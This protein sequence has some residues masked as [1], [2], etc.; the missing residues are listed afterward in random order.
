MKRRD[1]L[2]VAGTGAAGL[3]VGAAAG[4]VGMTLPLQSEIAKLDLK[5]H[6]NIFNWTYY[7]N[8]PQLV[9]WCSDHGITLVYDNFESGEELLAV[10][11]ATDVSG[12][13]ICVMTDGDIPY[14]VENEYLEPIDLDKIPNF[15]LLPEEFRGLSY[16]PENEHTVL[17]SY[18]TTG[19]G[20]N[21]DKVTE[22][23]GITK[24]A[25]IFDPTK[26]FLEKY[27]GKI[28][29]MPDVTETLGAALLYLGYSPNSTD[30]DELD[31]ALKPKGAIVVSEAIHTCEL[32]EGYQPTSYV[33]SELRGVFLLHEAPRTEFMSLRIAQRR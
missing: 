11:E 28:T 12:Y 29:M 30:S 23:K 33:C 26:G 6:L 25:D 3:A 8:R 22:E 13:D 5:G 27:D 15:E 32:I 24:W 9:K 4:Y 17:Y 1:F 19:I 2:K 14:S 20:W 16:D 31:E 7:L 18:G 21:S 10:I